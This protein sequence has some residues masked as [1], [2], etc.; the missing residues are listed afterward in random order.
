MK[1]TR[2]ILDGSATRQGAAH[3]FFVLGVHR[4]GTSVLAESAIRLGLYGGATEELDGAD[5]WNANGYWEHRAVRALDE[6]L[7]FAV[8]TDWF[9]G[10]AFDPAKLPEERRPELDARAT[11]IVESLDRHAPWV[12]KDPR[13]CVV[14]PYWRPLL[15]APAFLV[16][17]RHPVAVARSLRSRD[18]FPIQVGIAMWETQL[19]AALEASKGAPRAA[20]WYEDLVARPEEETE[21]LAAWLR[22]A[23]AGVAG[24]TTATAAVDTR[25]L[26]YSSDPVEDGELLPRG[27]RRLLDALRSSEAFADGFD[28]TASEDARAL[29]AFVDEKERLRRFLENG[30]RRQQAAHRAS[31]EGYESMLRARDEQLAEAKEQRR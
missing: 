3:Q 11:A 24:A 27:A 1:S 2:S 9:G 30:W 8:E 18:G 19:L 16:S 4:S 12:V 15:T 25:L 26:H 7:L 14:L 17:L 29:V 5:E 28:T 21:R 22:E 10:L 31:I 23:T 20:F 6:E 13:M